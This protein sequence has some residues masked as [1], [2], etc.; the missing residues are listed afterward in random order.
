MNKQQTII[1]AVV[2]DLQIR[3]T[4][5]FREVF[6]NSTKTFFSHAGMI[7]KYPGLD[8]IISNIVT[9]SLRGSHSSLLSGRENVALNTTIREAYRS[10]M[11]A[12]SWAAY[13]ASK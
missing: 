12:V 13:Q 1:I 11:N 5:E 6:L 9:E 3:N 2:S 10:A 8:N 7:G 4:G